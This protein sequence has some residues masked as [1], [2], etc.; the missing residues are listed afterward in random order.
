MS[1]TGPGATA[2]DDEEPDDGAA[3]DVTEPGAAE[4]AEQSEDPEPAKDAEPAAAATSTDDNTDD[5]D[6]DH[7]TDDG[8][9]RPGW[10]LVVALGVVAAAAVVALAVTAFLAPGWV[11]NPGS[12]D[13]TA[14][15][16]TTALATKDAGGLDAVSCRNQQG[17]STN[18]F[19]PDALPLVQ[20]ATP[21]GPPH[22]E[23]DTQA[24][25]P[26]DLVLSAPGRTQTLPA[27]IVLAVTDGHWCMAGVSQR[28]Q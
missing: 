1:D 11:V 17:R 3:T 5:H 12:P 18:P 10:G 22:L 26:V 14:T 21:S 7:D 20:T 4:E 9:R 13:D 23:L 15:R 28:Q 6:H 24:V 16:A 2:N 25:A 8:A 27:D 19:P